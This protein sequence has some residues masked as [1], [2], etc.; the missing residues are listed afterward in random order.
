METFPAYWAC[1][2]FAKPFS[3]TSMMEDV[4]ARHNTT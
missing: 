1:T 3:E 4:E 2:L